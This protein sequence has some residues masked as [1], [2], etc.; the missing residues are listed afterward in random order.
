MRCF[1]PQKCQAFAEAGSANPSTTV[2]KKKKE[3]KSKR[4]EKQASK[5]TNK[6]KV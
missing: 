2:I 1:Y 3:K 4:K 5:Q 6:Q